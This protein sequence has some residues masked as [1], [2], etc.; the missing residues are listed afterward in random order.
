MRGHHSPSLCCALALPPRPLAQSSPSPGEGRC[1]YIAAYHRPCSRVSL[2][3]SFHRWQPEVYPKL[4]G[5]TCDISR[6]SISRV[7]RHPP[8]QTP[9]T[10]STR[11][12]PDP[13]TSGSASVSQHQPS[14]HQTT[15]QQQWPTNNPMGLR[16]HTLL[17]RTMTLDPTN[18]PAAMDRQLLP[19]ANQDRM[20]H[21]AS[22]KTTTVASNRP[23]TSRPCSTSNSPC[24]LSKATLR[25]SRATTKMIEAVVAALAQAFARVSWVRWLVVVVWIACSRNVHEGEVLDCGNLGL[26]E[27][28]I[29]DQ[30]RCSLGREIR[31]GYCDRL[32]TDHF[33]CS[34]GSGRDIW[35]FIA[36][37]PF[38]F[39]LLV[40]SYFEIQ[41]L[42]SYVVVCFN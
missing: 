42:I 23:T 20:V 36:L 41:E 26:E 13:T 29:S 12:D 18:S 7:S 32:D 30:V 35:N 34:F 27:Q 17:R 31:V 5:T 28:M 16:H 22:S 24:T 38:I 33:F 39:L 11:P 19:W 15:P 10:S 40:S 9:P 8:A 4:G 1:S 37:Y 6:S 21:Q 2:S 25:S 14:T 3:A